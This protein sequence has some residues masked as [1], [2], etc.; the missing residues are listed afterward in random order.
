MYSAR[1]GGPG[2]DDEGRTALL[3]RELEGVPLRRRHARYR[4]VV[5]LAWPGGAEVELFEGIEEGA[6]GFERRGERGFGYDPVFLVDGSRTQAELS[7]EEKDAISHRGIAVR[8]AAAWLL[9]H[10]R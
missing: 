9:E 5:A 1:Y 2:L 3:L 4:A 10:N 8:A 6:I 7:D